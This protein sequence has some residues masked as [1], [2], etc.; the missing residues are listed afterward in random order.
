[1]T[2]L[3]LK[4]EEKVKEFLKKRFTRPDDA[5]RELI[6]EAMLEGASVAVADQVEK[7]RKEEKAKQPKKDPMPLKQAPTKIDQWVGSKDVA[8][9]TL[10][11]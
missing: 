7:S 2:A 9:G 3:E 11:K 8:P 5:D 10:K 6:R 4:I 1:M